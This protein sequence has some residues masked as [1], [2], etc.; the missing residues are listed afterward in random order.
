MLARSVTGHPAL[1]PGGQVD[2][3]HRQVRQLRGPPG[4]GS[5]V[6]FCQVAH[7]D[8]GRPAVGDDVM[9]HQREQV[10]VP[11]QADELDAQ[12]R[13]DLEVEGHPNELGRL[14]LG[15]GATPGIGTVAE[16]EQ[17]EVEGWQLLVDPLERHAS[18]GPEAGS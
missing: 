13:S 17:H 18:L 2:R 3:C 9:Q 11:A 7:D 6:E 1:L 4:Q 8:S 15:I 14:E 10:L 5:V 12:Q 16:I